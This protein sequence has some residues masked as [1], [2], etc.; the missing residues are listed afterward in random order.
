MKESKTPKFDAE[1]DK[2][3][4]E[5]VPHL[6]TCS[7]C[8]KEFKIELEDIDFYKLFR[9]PPSKLCPDCRQKNR[10]AFANYSNIYKRKC[11]VPGHEDIMISYV[12]PV[13]PWITYDYETYYSDKWDPLSYYKEIDNSKSFLEQY[14]NLLKIVPIAGVRRGANSINCDF[15]FYGKNMKDCYY[16]FGGRKSEDVM[17]SAS[18]YDS[19]HIVDSYFLLQVEGAYQNIITSDC[20]KNKYAYFSTNCIECNFIFDCRNCQNCFGCVNLR[21]KN[22]CFFNEQLSKEGYTN[23]IKS[24][25]LGSRKVTEEYQKMFWSLVKEN[26][27]RATRILKSENCVGNDIKESK[28]LYNVYQADNCENVRYSAFAVMSLR[29]SMDVNHSGGGGGRLYF[30]QNV[31]TKSSDVKFS[32]STKESSNC[33]YMIFSNN[34]HNCFGCSGIKNVSY[35]ILNKQYTPEEYWSKLDEIKT[36]MLLDKSY[37]E[38]FPMNFSPVAYNSSFANVMYPMSEKEANR[39]NLFWQP[40]TN[41]ESKNLERVE[42]DNIDDNISNID[43][44]ICDLAIIGK[45]SQKPFRI[46]QRELDFYKQNKIPVPKDTPYQ[47]MLDR[48]KILNNFKIYDEYCDKCNYPI[49]SAYRKIDGY[50]PYCEK[51]YMKEIY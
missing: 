50:K 22:Y 1:L 48:F 47:R 19:K 39:L 51:C 16:L 23:R 4:N 37:G 41:P 28:N 14:L 7:D 36:S 32:F 11:D 24:I 13:M 8:K 42:A 35:A 40:D 21:N 12:A 20:F 17:F 44:T 3:L 5:L 27:I 18:I 29:D 34:C 26:P 9:V 46:I 30:C 6:K 38:F 45:K 25:D 15:S 10:L 2:I 49:K 31:G 33:E 43:N